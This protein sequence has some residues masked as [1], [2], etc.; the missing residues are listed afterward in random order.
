ME[1][2]EVSHEKIHHLEP[3]NQKSGFEHIECTK[4]YV[5]PPRV[6]PFAPRTV[7]C[8]PKNPIDS[9]TT[10]H[11]SY[12]NENQLRE[13]RPQPFKPTPCINLPN[14]K[15]SDD[16]TTKLSFKP[17]WGIRKAA[18]IFPHQRLCPQKG[19][20]EDVTTIRQDYSPKIVAKPN[21]IIP[22]GNIR[23]SKGKLETATTT[24]L[25]YMNPG[26]IQPVTSFKPQTKYCRPNEPT[27]NETTQKLSY[28]PYQVGK[29]ENYP[30]AQKPIYRRPEAPMHDETTYGESYLESK[31]K[32]ESP[33][34]PKDSGLFS[35]GAQFLENTV[36]RDSFLPRQ[37]EPVAPIKP[38]A[39]LS[40]SDKK[41]SCDTTSKMSFR[42]MKGEM[43][44]P[45]VPRQR[46]ILC[47]AGS[48]QNVTT[49]QLEFTPKFV[50]R[51][52]VVVPCGH[53]R[54]AEQPL[55]AATTTA[56]SYVNPGPATHVPNYKP[57]LKYCKPE[58]K[59]EAETVNKLSYR[60]W[61]IGPKEQLPWAQKGKYQPPRDK[62]PGN[63]VYHMSF[64]PPGHF[65]EECQTEERPTST[66][67]D[68]PCPSYK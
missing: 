11:S 3:T 20:M 26:Q 31:G 56:L 50:R 7:Y 23:A 49:N 22:C 6:K 44:K 61:S 53:I 54:T 1:V 58:E 33:I 38:C 35:R 8:P 68:C 48:M 41:M 19:R 67:A 62:M 9:R 55:E 12:Y 5:Q 59:I 60:E 24:L 18:P 10:Y 16:T 42:P 36:Y 57:T 13:A 65:V 64:P 47:D 25:S 45:I 39:N 30:W 63:T 27:A 29:K 34:L 4:K 14:D 51:P 43:R 28:L 32:K 17:V 66:P 15:F 37:R 21:L 46:K 40:L 52:D 2:V